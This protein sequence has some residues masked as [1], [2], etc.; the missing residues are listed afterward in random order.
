MLSESPGNQSDRT[1]WTVVPRKESILTHYVLGQPPHVI[2]VLLT[3]SQPLLHLATMLTDGISFIRTWPKATTL[4]FNLGQTNKTTDLTH[5]I[6]QLHSSQKC[7]SHV[8]TNRHTWQSLRP[9]SLVLISI[10]ISICESFDGPFQAS[11][12]ER[13]TPS[14]PGIVD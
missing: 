9:N 13:L 4:S 5:Y 12:C 2:D 7:L 10:S 8:R 3:L 1:V 11:T 14:L 6:H